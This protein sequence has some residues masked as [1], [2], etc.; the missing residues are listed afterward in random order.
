MAQERYWRRRRSGIEMNFTVIGAAMILISALGGIV[1]IK[2]HT[3]HQ[4]IPVK[5]IFFGLYFWGLFFL[6]LMI[7]ALVYALNKHGISF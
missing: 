1:L 2:R 6:Q 5:L 3:E 7:F 4:Q